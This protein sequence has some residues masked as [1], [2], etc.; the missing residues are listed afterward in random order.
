M[1]IHFWITYPFQKKHLNYTEDIT[2]MGASTSTMLRF[3]ENTWIYGP[4]T[5][6]DL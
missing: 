5:I 1:N 2:I 4:P 6:R 3:M